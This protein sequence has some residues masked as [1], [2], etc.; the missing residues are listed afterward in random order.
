MNLVNFE[1]LSNYLQRQVSRYLSVGIILAVII[2]FLCLPNRSSD[3]KGALIGWYNFIVE[4]GG[5]SAFKEGFSDYTPLYVYWIFIASWLLAWLPK[6]MSIKLLSI[7]FD[8]ICA[9]FVYKLVR[10]KY[11]VGNMPTKAFL[12]VLFTPTVIYNSSL[13]GQCDGIYTTFLVAC[14]YYLLV[15]KNSLALICFGIAVSLKLQAMFILPVL[16]VAWWKKIVSWKQF[17]WIPIVYVITIIPAWL[18]GR[19]FLDL[20]LI[21]FGQSQ[22]FK[23]LTKNA[24]NLYQWI[25]NEFYNI[26]VPIGLS[27]TVFSILILTYTVVQSSVKIDSSRLVHLALASTL[28]MPYLLPK[29]HE[30]YFYPADI[31][32]MVF[33]FYLPQYYWVAIAVQFSSLMSYL[34]TKMLIKLSAIIL[35]VTLCFV[36]LK[37]KSKL[38]RSP[39]TDSVNLV[40]I[41]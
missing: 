16:L 7:T 5:F 15:N 19:P 35:G 30:R 4:H 17:L 31:F 14:L 20:L 22:K 3:M 41:Q 23:E 29:M 12:I 25:P 36:L 6:I 32:S 26:V 27:L 1:R 38:D 2:R 18:A 13:W 37:L 33:A 10:L 24:P 11:S 8:F 9:F 21:Y 28:L 40:Q 39:N 34:G